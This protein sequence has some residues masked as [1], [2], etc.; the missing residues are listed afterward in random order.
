MNLPLYQV[1]A[2]A[3][4]VFKGN[5]AAVC[6]LNRWLPDEM[7]QAIAM[8]NNLSETAF[9]VKDENSGTYR[10]RWFTPVSEVDLCGHATL[11]SAHVL[12]EH[13]NFG[14]DRVTFD[15]NS[16]NL[17][18]WRRDSWLVMDFP[19]ADYEREAP[20]M[21]LHNA[22]GFMAVEVYRGADYLWV[23]ESE[24]EVRKV[25]PDM[26]ELKNVQTRGVI[27]TAPA[28]NGQVDFVSRFF[29]PAVGVDED[30]VTG[31][32]H[33]MLI[34]Y[35]SGRLDK[36]EMIARQLS[37][38]GGTLKCRMAGKGRVEIAGQ[39]RTFLTGTINLPD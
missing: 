25:E 14:G 38:R 1:D 21:E 9:F 24:E 30:P 32:T 37:R 26:R 19:A 36:T 28:D 29:A 6:P 7:L 31:S 23:L 15:S 27:V 3:D 16:G 18:V 10:L 20:P 22:L 39:A 33:T 2:F 12:F 5:P 13:L 17:T 8:E 35:W 34:P 11:A 4:A